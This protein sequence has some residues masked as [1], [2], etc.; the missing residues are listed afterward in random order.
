V[1][2]LGKFKRILTLGDHMDKES[3]KGFPHVVTSERKITKG[4]RKILERGE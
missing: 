4:L 1:F 2:V 3:K